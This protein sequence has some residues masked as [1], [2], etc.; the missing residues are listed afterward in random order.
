M[1]TI[2]FGP[3]GKFWL[4]TFSVF[5]GCI[6]ITSFTARVAGQ[7]SL[8]D[9]LAL[10]WPGVVGVAAYWGGV[11]DSTPAP[12]SQAQRILTAQDET[13]VVKDDKAVKDASPQK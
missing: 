11:F 13:Q 3:Y 8:I 5:V 4:K 7:I 9:W 6:T 12:N 2:P 10:L 1:P